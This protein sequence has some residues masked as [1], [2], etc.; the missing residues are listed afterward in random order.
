MRE[1]EVKRGHNA[2][3]DEAVAELSRADLLL[4]GALAV[5]A[6]YGAAAVGPFVHRALADSGGNDAEV[7][8]YLLPFEY[9][10]VSFYNRVKSEV[11]DKGEK[12]KLQSKEKEFIDLLFS[13]EAQHVAA[14]E[15]RIEKLGAKPVKK[16]N[17]AFAFRI[18]EEVLSLAGELESTVVGA[19]N[20]AIP[21]MESAET[22]ELAYEIVQ[23]DARHAATAR[24]GV[25]E[26]PAPYAF[27]HGYPEKDA[28]LHVVPYTGVYPEE[29]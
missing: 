4:K 21:R 6:Y 7:L 11:N 18:F 28:I 3:R 17:Y 23:V 9:L 29:E 2:G 26:V 25:K 20:G 22:R 8:N 19:W 1:I 24:I 27:D 12:M 5:G 16:G 10:Q 14:V 13:Q 15:E